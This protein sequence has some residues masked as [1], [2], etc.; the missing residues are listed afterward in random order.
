M[1]PGRV[2]QMSTSFDV[3]RMSYS[4]G[5]AEMLRQHRELELLLYRGLIGIDMLMSGITMAMIATKVR[6]IS[7]T[8]AS[9]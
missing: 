1:T 7:K 5:D 6:A 8:V 2:V 9:A 3:D 4:E